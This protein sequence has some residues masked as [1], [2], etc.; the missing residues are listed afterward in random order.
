MGLPHDLRPL[1]ACAA[2]LAATPAALAQSDYPDRPVSIVVPWA[3]GGGADTIVR[4][5][6][7]DFEQAMGVPINVVNRT[8]G[9]GVVGHTAI[10]TARPDGYTLGACTSEIGYFDRLG[11]AP[12]TPDSFT[13]VS[14]LGTIPAGLTVRSGTYESAESLVAA[15]RAGETVR[16][17]GSGIAGPW[18]LAIAGLLA[19]LDQ[20]ATSVNFIPSQGGAPALQ[21]LVAGGLDLFTGSPVEAR[22]LAQAGEVD[23][24]AVMADERMAAFP[25]TPTL[26]EAA[27][28]DWTYANWF[29]LCAPADLPQDVLDKVAEA[30]ERAMSAPQLRQTLAERGVSPTWESPEAFRAFADESRRTIGDLLV[31]LQLAR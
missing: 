4:L 20:P 8:G 12:L 5:F 22:A 11:L 29:S 27:G 26:A 15:L 1:I 3:A 24:L 23:I 19:S 13:L 14:R 17:S 2:L 18:H 25:D 30:G 9:N 31:D 21:D 16:A 10:A 28:V 7:I 6:A